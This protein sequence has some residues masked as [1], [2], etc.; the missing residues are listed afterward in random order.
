MKILTTQKIDRF[1]GS[2]ILSVLLFFR[3]LIKIFRSK[4][5]SKNTNKILFVKFLGMGSIISASPAFRKVKE[6]YPNC[7][8]TVLTDISNK[9]ICKCLPGIDDVITVNVSGFLVFFLS[10]FNA[11]KIAH[12]QK[13]DYIIDFEFFASISAIFTLILQQGIFY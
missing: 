1:F 4:K 11:I 8:V 13:F 3:M 10:F 9:E 12:N 6:I 5:P 2:I 7:K